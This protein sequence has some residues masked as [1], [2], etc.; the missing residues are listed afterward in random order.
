DEIADDGRHEEEDEAEHGADPQQGRIDPEIIGDAGA[1]AREL[2]ALRVAVE[3]VR[4]AQPAVAVPEA[5]GLLLQPGA[6]ASK[7]RSKLS[8]RPSSL[9]ALSHSS[10]S[11]RSSPAERPRAARQRV[12]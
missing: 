5:H 4:V 3:A 7:A 10:A 11:M 2:A 8:I 1:D 6:S 12:T 9:H